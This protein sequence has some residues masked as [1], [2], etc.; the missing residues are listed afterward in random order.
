MRLREVN[1]VKS[2]TDQVR[3]TRKPNLILTALCTA[4]AAFSEATTESATCA[5][6]VDQCLAQRRKGRKESRKE[7]L[8]AILSPWRAIHTSA[9]SHCQSAI[10]WVGDVS[11]QGWLIRCEKRP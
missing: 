4:D 5:A 7:F 2:T 10:I 11:G 1:R 8:L 9:I 3:F 6:F